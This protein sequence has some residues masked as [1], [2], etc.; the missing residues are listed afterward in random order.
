[1]ERNKKKMTNK[2]KTKWGAQ[3]TTAKKILLKMAV[4]KEE[5]VG[6]KLTDG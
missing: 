5:G 6:G 4:K 3:A 2:R 1:L